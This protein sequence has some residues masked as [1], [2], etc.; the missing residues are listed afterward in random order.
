[1]IVGAYWHR[2]CWINL[3]TDPAYQRSTKHVSMTQ[4]LV[5]WALSASMVGL[6]WLFTCAI[7]TKERSAKRPND[8]DTLE[9]PSDCA[10]S[11]PSH[12]KAAA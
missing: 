9:A 2:P 4:E 6:V 7:L 1:M 12:N 5:L 3:K 10:E 11:K 8:H